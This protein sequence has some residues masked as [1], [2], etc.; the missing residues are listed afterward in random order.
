MS[1]GILWRDGTQKVPTY[2]TD[3]G[4][5]LTVRK[6]ADGIASLGQRF[7]VT[8]FGAVG[9]G[10]TDDATAFQAAI[11]A[12]E[13]AGGG[14]VI[15]RPTSNGYK[16]DSGLTFP[17]SEEV[18]LTGYGTLITFGGT[19]GTLF[20]INTGTDANGARHRITGLDIRQSTGDAGDGTAIR[21][22][23]SQFQTVERCHIKD[24]DKGIA[25]ETVSGSNWCESIIMRDLRIRSC[26]YG[27]YFEAA[28][29]ESM[30]S[31]SFEN[32]IISTVGATTATA[33]G[34]YIAGTSS[35]QANIYRG[36][37]HKLI[38]FVDQD[39]SVGFYCDG[40][41]RVSHGT[42]H[43]ERSGSATGTVGFEFGANATLMQA[44]ITTDITGTI[45][46]PYK[47]DAGNTAF[48][49]G[50]QDMKAVSG[51]PHW[52][53]RQGIRSPIWAIADEDRST[54]RFQCRVESDDSVQFLADSTSPIAWIDAS[55]GT[56]IPMRLHDVGRVTTAT[57]GG[58][59]PDVSD[60]TTLRLNNSS[61]GVTISDFTN[62]Y[63]NQKLTVIHL[64]NYTTLQH[65]ASTIRLTCSANFTAASTKGASQTFVYDSPQSAWFEV[66][67][68]EYST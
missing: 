48:W 56:L 55:S 52:M 14:V 60:T 61:S 26:D 6:N 58:T 3:V 34:V 63:A 21:I 10:V 54:L 8:T 62:P 47:F 53:R 12:A 18:H 9:D 68:I 29:A 24:F 23:D 33:Y 31:P 65:G 13:A 5:T 59:T 66:S 7:D 49:S 38:I 25:I 46:T 41:I 2:V 67:R 32:V 20:E 44:D 42:I 22:Y 16:I 57:T 50:W 64:N 17:T 11:D 51:G 36:E 45:G 39:D 27:V 37:F 4:G 28:A 40:K 19:T 1:K 35:Q 30:A 15:C 43:I